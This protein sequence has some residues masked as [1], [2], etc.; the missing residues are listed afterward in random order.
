MN[1]ETRMTRSSGCSLKRRCPYQA[2]VMNTLESER[3]TIGVTWAGI[4]GRVIAELRCLQRRS[5]PQWPC[6]V[7]SATAAATEHLRPERWVVGAPGI[8]Q[9]DLIHQPREADDTNSHAADRTP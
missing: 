7:E 5:K 4:V 3:S 1:Q 6:P 8:P 2:K 9:L